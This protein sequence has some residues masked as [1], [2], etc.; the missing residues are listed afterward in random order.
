MKTCLHEH[1]SPP[2]HIPIIGEERTDPSLKLLGRAEV[3]ISEGD[4]Y[5]KC[6]SDIS[7]TEEDEL[8]DR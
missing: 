4:H 7:Q 2:N 5:E 6:P 3:T 1:H 8:C